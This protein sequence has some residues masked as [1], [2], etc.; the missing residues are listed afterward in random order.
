MGFASVLAGVSALS[1]A[2]D[3]NEIDAEIDALISSRPANRNR[4]QIDRYLE[5]NPDDRDI[6]NEY[7]TAFAKRRSRDFGWESL[8]PLIRR[9]IPALPGKVQSLKRWAFEN[10]SD[11]SGAR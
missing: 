9:R 1:K 7:L 10:H 2:P 5:E 6:L 11:F 8:Y 3:Q 4:S